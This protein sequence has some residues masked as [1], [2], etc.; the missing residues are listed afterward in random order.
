[1]AENGEK[2]ATRAKKEKPAA[3]V[4]E[5]MV[6]EAQRDPLGAEVQPEQPALLLGVQR[7]PLGAEAQRDR[8]VTEV[9]EL[10]EIQRGILTD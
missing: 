3:M 7:D 9:N 5:A 2:K 1:M 10:I 8:L 4:T 6:T